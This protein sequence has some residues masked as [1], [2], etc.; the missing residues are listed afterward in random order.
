MAKLFTME[1]PEIYDGIIE[2][3][4]VAR[5][6]G[7]RAKIAVVSRDSSI[8]PVGACVGMRGSRVQAVVGE[9]A[10]ERIDIIPW[11]QD[12]A[13][14][15]VN[16]LQPAE[17]T[18]VVLDEDAERIEVVVPDDQLSLAI[19]RRGQ[20]VRLASQ[21]TGWDIDI[22]T[23]DEESERRQKEFQERSQLF[24]EALDVDEMVGQLLASEG[25]ASVEEI[26]FVERDE[27][28]SIE[29]FDE[30]TAEELQAR[31]REHLERVEAEQDENR[32]KLGV[33]DDLREVPGITTAMMV[34]LG[35]ND[36]KTLEDLAYCA[37]DDLVGWVERRD[38][39]AIRHEGAL[40]GF[41]LSRQEAEA[42]VMAARLKAG[43][44]TE[45]DLAP[46]EEEPATA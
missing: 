13:T 25:F 6:P 9:L 1:V 21:L 30:E 44:L 8:D 39:E 20:N 23:E 35:E 37:T 34:A 45:S 14:F 40:S 43:I 33:A 18:K 12:A 42:M 19:G 5:D 24:I 32:L 7:S 10:G 41:D 29:G 11:N 28:A 22:L 27:L 2:I 26:A 31:A 38:G 15:I 46:R 3:K 36:I 17:V 4:S 16:S